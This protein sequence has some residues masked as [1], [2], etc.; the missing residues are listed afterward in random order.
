MVNK[1]KLNPDLI[2]TMAKLFELGCTAKATYDAVRVSDTAYMRWIKVGEEAAE[3]DRENLT[4]WEILCIE[5]V[6]KT[7][8]AQAK[9]QKKNLTIIE[10][11]APKTWQA[12]A[13]L[14]ERR[15]PKDFSIY[16]RADIRKDERVKI[17]FEDV[18]P[19]EEKKDGRLKKHGGGKKWSAK[20]NKEQKKALEEAAKKNNA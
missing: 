15:N 11:A 7:N 16:S 1:T 13:W 20:Q 9:F 19:A 14:L 12:S 3:K 8:Q 2:S 17:T 4:P 10:K 6:E 5:L 18:K